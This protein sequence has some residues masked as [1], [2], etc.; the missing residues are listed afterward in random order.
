VTLT[1]LGKF[2]GRGDLMQAKNAV[3]NVKSGA[4]CEMRNANA[5]AEP[6]P[7]CAVVH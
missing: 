7:V 1:N 3:R 2:F 5:T 4:K 6:L